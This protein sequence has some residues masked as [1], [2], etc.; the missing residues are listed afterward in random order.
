MHDVVI[1]VIK[2]LAGGTLVVVFALI[3]QGLEPKRF[4]GLFS[5]APAVALAGLTVTL[6]DK[7]AHDAHQSSAGM[8]AGAAAMAVYAT[9]VIPLLRRARPGVAA[10]A[11]LGVWTAAAAVVAVPLLAG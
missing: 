8:I 4:A 9:A 5:A 6:L 3:S 2:A 7:G 11:A 10:I 1:L